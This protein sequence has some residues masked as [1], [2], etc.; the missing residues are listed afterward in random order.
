MVEKY[1]TFS[2]LFFLLNIFLN[3]YFSLWY[4]KIYFQRVII[5]GSNDEIFSNDD[6]KAEEK[7]TGNKCDFIIWNE[8]VSILIIRK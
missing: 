8:G 2:S 5:L 7:E 6:D 1:V 4:N 3:F